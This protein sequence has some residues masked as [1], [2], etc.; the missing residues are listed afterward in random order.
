MKTQLKTRSTTLFE[1]PYL[2]VESLGQ[3]IE[4]PVPKRYAPFDVQ[5]SS[6][7]GHTT[8]VYQLHWVTLPFSD[9]PVVRNAWEEIDSALHSLRPALVARPSSITSLRDSPV[10][11]E[12]EGTDNEMIWAFA[13][14][15]GSLAHARRPIPHHEE[16]LE[17]FVQFP[18]KKVVSVTVT[19]VGR[20]KAQPN[21]ILE[22]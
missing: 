5:L 17:V 14:A 4:E 8:G 12:R 3:A 10:R 11:I 15:W 20:S 2:S 7:S 18:P 9:W 13:K 21:P 6:T 22:K 1:S 19:I 16:E